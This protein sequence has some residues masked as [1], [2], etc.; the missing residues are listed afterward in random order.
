VSVPVETASTRKERA[1]PSTSASFAAA[2]SV[3]YEI[4]NAVSSVAVARVDMLV[5]VGAL[6]EPALFIVMETVEIPEFKT[7]SLAL[8]V[9]ESFPV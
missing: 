3:A 6:P 1:S 8:K 5:R 2:A 7:P 4:V 9:K